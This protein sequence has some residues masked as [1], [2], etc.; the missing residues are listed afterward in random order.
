MRIVVV[1]ASGNI[2]IALLRAL[3][4]ESATASLVGVSRRAPDRP[5]TVEWRSADIARDELEPI[6]EGADA[7]VSLA[8]RIQPS[9][10]PTDLWHTNV[11]GSARVFEA[12]ARSNVP[13]LVYGSS[14][15]AYAPGPQGER[16]DESW[17]TTG[18]RTS[19]YA[20]HKAEVERRLDA[21][22]VSHPAIRV[23]RMRPALVFQRASA[24]EQRRFFLGP[25]MPRALLR[26]GLLPIVPT[27]TGLRF[28]AVHADDVADAYRRVLLSDVRGAFNVATEPVLGER[29]IASLLRA[30]AFALP[31]TVARIAVASTWHLRLQPTPPGWLDMGLGVPL[32]DTSRARS[33]LGWEPRHDA[34]A[35]LAQVISG[36][37]RGAGAATPPLEP[38]AG[39]PARI[40]EIATLLGARDD[41]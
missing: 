36:M 40:G 39:G 28:Q 25:L 5:G 15:G 9:H 32:M 26:R 31:P 13:T 30:R 17:P 19:F 7:V 8:W 1:G 38:D 14:V 35:T 20:R 29:A 6:F 41:A 37:R 4:R 34:H 12:V 24:T 23:V 21:F 11:H 22:E 2:G 16:V 18:V 27:V 3:E 10:R 33:L